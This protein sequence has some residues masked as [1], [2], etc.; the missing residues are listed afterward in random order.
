MIP[1]LLDTALANRGAI[2]CDASSRR[3]QPVLDAGPV[4]R[5]FRTKFFI[6]GAITQLANA[7]RVIHTV[8]FD[9]EKNNQAKADSGF[10]VFSS[11]ESGAQ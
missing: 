1:D 9:L 11:P 8:A 6:C 7:H 5:S 2:D 10:I 4:F 3:F